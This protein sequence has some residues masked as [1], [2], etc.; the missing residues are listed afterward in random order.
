MFPWTPVEVSH[1]Q[2]LS[3]LLHLLPVLSAGTSILHR[4]LM[5]CC[6]LH[7]CQYTLLMSS[8]DC[9]PTACH[10]GF[11]K[12]ISGAIYQGVLCRQTGEANKEH[13]QTAAFNP[14]SSWRATV[15]LNK[16]YKHVW[17]YQLDWKSFTE[18]SVDVTSELIGKLISQSQLMVQQLLFDLIEVDDSFS[19]SLYSVYSRRKGLSIRKIALGSLV[20]CN[21]ML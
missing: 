2:P 12:I 4:M 11:N 1:A 18:H 19:V 6:N 15:F 5:F 13:F 3:Y 9:L 14:P 7:W 17:T 21:I 20:S 16:M 10:D 8:G